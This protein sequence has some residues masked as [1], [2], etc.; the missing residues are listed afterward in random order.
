MFAYLTEIVTTRR[1]C[2]ARVTN[3]Q[4]VGKPKKGGCVKIGTPSY[5]VKIKVAA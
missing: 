1:P 5:L 3:G 4:A 2:L